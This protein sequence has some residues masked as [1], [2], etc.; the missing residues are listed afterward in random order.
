[1]R[2]FSNGDVT[3]RFLY[4]VCYC[5]APEKDDIKKGASKYALHFIGVGWF[6]VVTSLT[7]VNE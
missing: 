1:M 2:T 7:K 6:Y 5:V 3:K 4:H